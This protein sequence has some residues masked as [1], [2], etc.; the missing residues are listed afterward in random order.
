MQEILDWL[1]NNIGI[2]SSGLFGLLATL[3]GGKFAFIRKKFAQL[4]ELLNEIEKATADDKITKEELQ[5]I[6][7][8]AKALLGKEDKK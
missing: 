3:F 1:L 4:V 2:V 7:K 8:D 5:E 6:I